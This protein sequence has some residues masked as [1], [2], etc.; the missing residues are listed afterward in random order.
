VAKSSR[1]EKR[2]RKRPG[3]P[4][5][6]LFLALEPTADDRLAL[7]RWRDSVV[8]GRDDLRPVA[9]ETL[10]LTLAFLGYRPEKEIA[11]I[12]EA[13]FEPLADVAAVALDPLAVV[14]VPRRGPRLFAL[15]LGDPEG[16]AARIQSLTEAAL[17]AR[18]FHRP[19]K[20][21]WWPHVTLARVKRGMRA[22][23]LDAEPP[24]GPLRATQVTLYRSTL[25][26]QGALYE[27]QA[28][29]QLRPVLRA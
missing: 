21:A 8:A 3:S 18:R 12:A 26:P 2:P 19:E 9:A 17:A 23:P 10:H 6:R 5:A 22:E 20:R 14:P 1:S 27:A 25:R 29:F 15:D 7:A 16:G 24:A 11:A 4:R 28:S 13:A